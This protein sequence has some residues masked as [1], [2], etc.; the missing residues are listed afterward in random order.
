MSRPRSFEEKGDH[1]FPLFKI[2]EKIRS[3]RRCK[4]CKRNM[5]PLC[6]KQILNRL[7]N[8]WKAIMRNTPARNIICL[9]DFIGIINKRFN[10][11][12]NFPTTI[13]LDENYVHS[14]EYSDIIHGIFI[15]FRDGNVNGSTGFRIS[16]TGVPTDDKEI[17]THN[18]YNFLEKST[19]YM[20]RGITEN[21]FIEFVFITLILILM[22]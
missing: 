1:H 11:S 14:K 12:T 18:D 4:N 8:D 16:R 10:E 17:M 2:I 19:A 15:E 22:S 20:R 3:Y 5:C 7:K 9:S 21:N 13:C 6:K